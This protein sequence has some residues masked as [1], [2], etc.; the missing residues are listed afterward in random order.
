[1]ATDENTGE[2]FALKSLSKSRLK[3]RMRQELFRSNRNRRRGPIK[4]PESDDPLAPIRE[5]S[6]PMREMSADLAASGDEI[7]LLKKFVHP[8]IAALREV[9][10]VPAE[11]SLYLGA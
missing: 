5:L 6:I 8:N 2:R 9:L 11:D 4:T 10:D 1:M 7:S 3:K